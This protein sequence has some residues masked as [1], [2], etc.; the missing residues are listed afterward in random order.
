MSNSRNE[1]SP[2]SNPH[3]DQPNWRPATDVAGY[4]ANCREGLEIYSDNRTAKLMGW[5]R[6]H[7]WRARLLAAIPD[8]IFEELVA[9]PKISTSQLA[10]A[11]RVFLGS[12]TP[13]ETERC[14]HC[15]GVLRVRSRVPSAVAAIVG[16]AMAR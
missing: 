13:D 7:V 15:H 9:L 12:A 4:L 1:C 8:D 2:G 3:A 14:P 6:A 16:K 10:A 11:G 5:S